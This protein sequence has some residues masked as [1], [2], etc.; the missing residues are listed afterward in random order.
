MHMI[1]FLKPVLQSGS[2]LI[3]TI[4]QGLIRS[5]T[6]KRRMRYMEWCCHPYGWPLIIGQDVTIGHGACLHGCTVGNRVLIGIG[7]IILDGAVIEDEVIVGAGSLVPPGKI[8]QSGYLYIGNPAKP[9]RPLKK[10]EIHFFAYSA[11]N[12][13]Q[14][15]NDYLDAR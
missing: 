2:I 4:V 13:V 9:A 15:K 7:S 5:W 1:R 10:S 12:Y 14:L 6:E 3:G 11:Q 8:L